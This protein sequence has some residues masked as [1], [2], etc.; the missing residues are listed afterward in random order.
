MIANAYGLS[1][2]R[3]IDDPFANLPELKNFEVYIMTDEERQYLKDVKL[4]APEGTE[5]V[6]KKESEKGI[7]IFKRKE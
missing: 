6:Q 4:I 3:I 7:P 2:A 5:G 1:P